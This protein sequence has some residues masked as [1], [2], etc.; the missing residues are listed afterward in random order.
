MQ[1]ALEMYESALRSVADVCDDP[2]FTEQMALSRA[3]D[4]QARRRISGS[5]LQLVLDIAK[6]WWRDESPLGLLEFVEEGNVILMKTI[7]AYKGHTAADFLQ[8][9][10][11]NLESW[12]T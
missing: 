11:Q 12:F 8:R 7:K 9:V 5:C 6:R 10:T 2:W 1:T 4:E 3:G